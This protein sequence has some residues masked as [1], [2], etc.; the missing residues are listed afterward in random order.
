MVNG[1][2]NLTSL[3]HKL[4][5][6]VLKPGDL[7]LDATAGN[8]FDTLFL[9]TVVGKEG[10]VIA[11]DIQEE[12]IWRTGE[13][14]NREGVECPMSLVIGCHSELQSFVKKGTAQAIMFNLG[15]LP[16]SDREIVTKP[17]TTIRALKAAAECLAPG[18]ILTV[19]AYRGHKEGIVEVDEVSRFFSSLE[20]DDLRVEKIEA[21]MDQTSPLLFVL[22]RL[23]EVTC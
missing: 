6:E 20:S 5:G 8:G 21:S 15:F 4:V 10:T 19:I 18:G 16:R 14:L 12:A 2:Q 13:L 7:A 11:I 23:S 3:A 17:E 22:R 1:Y 9:A